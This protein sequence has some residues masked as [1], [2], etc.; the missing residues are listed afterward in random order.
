MAQVA[1]GLLRQQLPPGDQVHGVVT[2]GSA[3]ANVIP[4]DG[5]R[6]LHGP[7]RAPREGLAALRP[8]V[9]ACFEAG[10]LATGCEV[11][12]EE[13]SPVYS[14]METGPGAAARPTAP[15]PR[16]SGGGSTPTTPARPRRPSRPTWPTS[17]WPCP[18]STRSSASRRRRRQPPAG[19]R[20]R[21]RHPLGRRRRARR[22][23]GAGLDRHRRRHG[24]RAARP[25]ARR[26][27]TEHALLDVLAG[28]RG[29]V[30]RGDGDGEGASSPPAPAS[31]PSGSSAASSD[32]S[33]FLLLVE[34]ERLEDHTE[35]FRGSAA[36]E[37]WRA[38]LHHFYDPFPVVEHFEAVVSA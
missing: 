30:R 24:S 27:I 22:G 7:L 34:W 36:Y 17:R 29:R 18:R 10:A 1:I 6:P 31:S 2:A 11:A 5:H 25:P 21:L 28:Q 14:H 23:R 32:P 9:D 3:A 20:R 15:T 26:M 38:A 8:R 35:G 19:V 16:R 33:R 37:A 4:A 12:Y 13:L